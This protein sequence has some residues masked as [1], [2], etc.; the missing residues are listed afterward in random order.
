MPTDPIDDFAQHLRVERGRSEHTVRAYVGDLR[1]LDAYAR[2]EGA[3]GLLDLGLVDL[4][5]W[6]A[7]EGA[8]G[9]ARATMARRSAAA[10]TFYAW[11]ARRGL[12]AEDPAG[13]L[14]SPRRASTLPGVLDQAQAAE[15][16]AV[17]ERSTDPRARD[18]AA[19][20]TAARKT[21]GAG[22]TAGSGESPGAGESASAGKTAGSGESPGAGE[23][24]GSVEGASP[25]QSTAP[26]GSGPPD[27]LALRDVAMVELLY[28]SGIRVS[29]LAGLDVDDLDAAARTLRVLGK[30]RKERT[31][32]YG[33][34]A[35][36]AVERWLSHGRPLLVGG[37]SGPALFLGRRGRRVD[38]RQVRE[39]VHRLLAQVPGAPDLG[40]H[41]LRHSAATHL[42]DGGADLRVVQELL[43]HS[44]L[45]TTQIY[46][47]VSVD[48]L[49]R[50][51]R[52]AH[53]R[54]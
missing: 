1:R 40:P 42:L 33:L 32:P 35:A 11:A 46:T 39:V 25:G 19:R 8:G 45:A 31:V 36:Q 27:P 21:A 18:S 4:R 5:S 16:L 51:Y 28:A 29:E 38:P 44:S 17:A 53:P 50:A 15:M 48:R 34:P 30:G 24:A 20:G 47:H 9:A 23:T 2:G 6:L 14:A 54:A 49:R 7:G 37:G 41:G 26:D 52:Q 3:G 10:R 22:K 12:V 13:R 43:G